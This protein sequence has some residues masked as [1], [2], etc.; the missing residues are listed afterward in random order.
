[1]LASL[2][3]C[4]AAALS[5]VPS[6]PAS[7]PQGKP[8][9]SVQTR[10]ITDDGRSRIQ[11][12][13][14]PR[15][16]LHDGQSGHISDMTQTPFVTSVT[17]IVGDKTTA[18]QPVI[19]VLSEG[20]QVNLAVTGVDEQHAALDITIEQSKLDGCEE[21]N[22][23]DSPEGPT[24]QSPRL[25]STKVRTIKTVRLGEVTAIKLAKDNPKSIELTV[26]RYESP[27]GKR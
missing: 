23:S 13:A 16:T 6:P 12:L 5:A 19:T 17:K 25:V 15:V 10:F 1:M 22:L 11:T 7:T 20:V 14:A 9:W 18:H 3:L 26:K 27:Y 4:S 21:V 2:L 8:Q 24:V